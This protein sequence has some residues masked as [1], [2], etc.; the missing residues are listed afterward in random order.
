MYFQGFLIM[1]LIR[2]MFKRQHYPAAII[3]Q[4]CVRRYLAYALSLRNLEEMMAERGIDV[5]HST[6]YRWVL[7]LVPVMDKVAQRYKRPVSQKW[8]I[9][10]AYIKIKGQWHCLYRSVDS[11]GNIIDFL[12]TQHWDVKAAKRFFR[13]AISHHPCPLTV[14]I[15]NNLKTVDSFNDGYDRCWDSSLSAVPKSR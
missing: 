12:L 10:E 6:L 15:D 2:N 9:D 3:V 11:T 4:C 14:A 8:H 1:T 7:R 5:D 13:Q